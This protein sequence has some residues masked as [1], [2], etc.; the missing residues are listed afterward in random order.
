M[1][2]VILPEHR[3]NGKLYGGGGGAIYRVSCDMGRKPPIA[4]V[5]SPLPLQ[6]WARRPGIIW[7][8][9]GVSG[10]GG[11]PIGLTSSGESVLSSA[12]AMP[13]MWRLLIITREKSS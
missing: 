9:Y 5:N 11:I 8:L 7:R 2:N 4:E 1:T 13:T 12:T 3:A 6:F 10:R